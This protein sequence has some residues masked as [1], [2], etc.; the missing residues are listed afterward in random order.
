MIAK[1]QY[2][3][4]TGHIG[5]MN[6]VIQRYL[7]RY[8]IQLRPAARQGITEP[9]I[10]LNPYALTLQKAEKLAGLIPPPPI[11]HRPMA[12]SEAVNLVEAVM[13]A[14]EQRNQSLRQL[15]TQL[16]ETAS[17]ITT[18]ENFPQLNIHALAGLEAVH[19]KIGNM[20]LVNYRKYEK[21]MQED[22]RI[23]FITAKRDAQL[24]W[25]AY[26]TPASDY[27]SIDSIFAA[28][29]FEA[30][31]LPPKPLAGLQQE[32][33]SLQKE[34]TRL[35][36]EIFLN[37]T[38]GLK[39]Q[40]LAIACQRVQSLYA[41]FDVKKYAALSKNRRIFSFAG[42]MA[43]TDAKQLE[44][45][46]THDNLAVLTLFPEE[47]STP[48]TL[49]KNPLIIRQ[50]EFFT[51]LYG[52]PKYGEV[53]PTP[54]L[55]VTYT[56][57]FGLM[58][59]D[60]GHGLVIG[61]LG[62][63][64]YYN[65]GLALGGIMAVVGGSAV[66]FGFLYGSIFGREDI[67]PALW[68]R[69]VASINQ[70]L[71]FAVLLGVFLIVLAMLFYMYNALRQRRY[72]DLLFGANGVA[73]F[74]F[75]AGVVWLGL[76]LVGGQG[77]TWAVATVAAIPLVFVALKRPL[78]HAMAGKKI[79]PAGGVGQFLFST[80]IETFETLL[81]YATNTI[82]FV[83]VGAFAISHAG[84]MHV[85]LQLAQ[86]AAGM[87]NIIIFILGNALVLSIEG[88]LVGIQALRLDFYEI[89]SRFYTGGGEEIKPQAFAPGRLGEQN[90]QFQASQHPLSFFEKKEAKRF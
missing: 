84:M 5:S 58:F 63:F 86:G 30:A 77:F 21:F 17:H 59:G 73:G 50:F 44:E 88:L 26:F 32:Y 27:N 68:M 69:P 70:T 16:A 90:A 75:Y 7:S 40:R 22:S 20:S 23:I 89:F 8:H 36:Q 29:G 49:L 80:A 24:V 52:L 28:L 76:R 33:D 53:D 10:S 65:K 41:S 2:I 85:V 12:A 82:S 62:L 1:M 4:I 31:K 83:R 47:K 11:F 66:V 78:G 71:I 45:E 61:L 3:S 54:L 42:W 74:L 67:L 34:V 14:Y 15:E 19:C 60:V 72:E 18:Y 81:T 56:L 48:P 37:I 55:A 6:H 38:P 57:L 39:P 35:T 51:R 13:Q 64:L 46:I 25:G 9:F 87:G 79:L 43:A